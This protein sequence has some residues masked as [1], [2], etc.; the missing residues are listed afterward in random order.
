M[1]RAAADQPGAVRDR[2]AAV[3]PGLLAPVQ[4][5]LRETA[6]PFLQDLY[7]ATLATVQ[8]T[9]GA[10]SIAVPISVAAQ[11]IAALGI[12]VP[13][14]RGRPRLVPAMHVAAQ[15]IARSL[16]PADFRSTEADGGLAGLAVL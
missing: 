6:A 3:G 4:T 14:L 11:T 12:L 10:C 16:A 9:L 7:G 15:G 1:G 8:M 5:G 2:S 13:D